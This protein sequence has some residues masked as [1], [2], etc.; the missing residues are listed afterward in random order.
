M[1]KEYDF[2]DSKKN[3]YARLLKR[4]ITIRLGIEVIAY[5]KD[6]S[7]RVGIPYQN[8]INLYL[9]ECADS[10]KRPQVHWGH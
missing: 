1:R 7:R 8:L 3:P 9:K 6:L 4:Q 5:F 2:L 10:K